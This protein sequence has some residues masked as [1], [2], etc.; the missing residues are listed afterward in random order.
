[1]ENLI[2]DL[3]SEKTVSDYQNENHLVKYEKEILNE[4]LT[5]IQQSDTTQLAWFRQFCRSLRHITMNVYAYRK[6]IEFDFT[7]I[8][9]DQYG[10]F[11]RPTFLDR[12]D[13]VFGNPDRYSEHSTIHL[14][15][16]LNHIW[17]YTLNYSYGITGGGSF[18][19]VYDK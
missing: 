10:W 12:E 5:A 18:I 1:M 16:G 8:G 7:E 15:R 19:S 17:T 9:F 14:G 4:I 13:M 11:T 2:L 6:G 3:H